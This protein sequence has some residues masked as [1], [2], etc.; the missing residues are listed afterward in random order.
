LPVLKGGEVV[1]VLTMDNLGEPL[2]FQSA[3]RGDARVGRI[4]LA[5]KTG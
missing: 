1:G 2:M 3:L 4:R 5:E